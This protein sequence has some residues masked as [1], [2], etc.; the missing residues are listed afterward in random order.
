MCLQ[1]MLTDVAEYPSMWKAIC[2][3]FSIEPESRISSSRAHVSVRTTSNE[4][5]ADADG[6]RSASIASASD[7]RDAIRR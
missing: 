1:A 5:S 2:E 6:D 4:C 3:A 7:H